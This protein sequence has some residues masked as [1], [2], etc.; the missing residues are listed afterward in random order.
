MNIHIMGVPE[1]EERGSGVKRIVE[2]ITTSKF[3]RKLPKSS[4]THEHKNPQSLMNS[5]L[6]EL[7]GTHS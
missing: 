6:D 4:A 1:G 7:K 2:E 3:R 5:K